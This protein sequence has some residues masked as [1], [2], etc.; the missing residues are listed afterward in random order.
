MHGASPLTDEELIE[1]HR[2]EAGAEESSPW[3]E[4]LFGRYRRRVAAWCLKTVDERQEALDLAQEVFL[5]AF[6]K[7]D[8]FQ[9][10]SRFSTWLYAV[11]RNHCLNAAE[12]RSRQPGRASDEEAVG[13][14]DPHSESLAERLNRRMDNRALLDFLN[15]SLDETEQRVMMMHYGQGYTLKSVTRLLS[16]DNA[17]GAKAYIVS[18]RRKIDKALDRRQAELERRQQESRH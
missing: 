4:E 6:Q 9:G 16:L 1:R 17:S 14:P 10:R 18:A 15:E 7:L 2:K 13:L 5:K 3:L 11:A 8:S 12:A